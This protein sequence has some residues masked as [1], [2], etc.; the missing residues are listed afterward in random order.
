MMAPHAADV[1]SCQVDGSG[2]AVSNVSI[3]GQLVGLSSGFH[4][5]HVHAYGNVTQGLT[6]AY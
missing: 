6:G 5:F 1:C 2:N 3:S 4:G